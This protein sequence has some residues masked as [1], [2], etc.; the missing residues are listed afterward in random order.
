[1][2][3]Y[4]CNNIITHAL[5]Y[6]HNNYEYIMNCQFIHFEPYSFEYTTHTYSLFKYTHDY[7]YPIL[8]QLLTPTYILTL[9]ETNIGSSIELISPNIT[10]AFLS[11]N[12]SPP[13]R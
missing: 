6:T 4:N 3:E 11:Y 10:P 7:Y 9:F 2:E 1:M 12:L 5:S 8:T 13:H